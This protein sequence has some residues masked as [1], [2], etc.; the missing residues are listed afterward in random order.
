VRRFLITTAALLASLGTASAV[1]AEEVRVGA[2]S[3]PSVLAPGLPSPQHDALVVNVAR[4]AHLLFTVP[5]AG[6]PVLDATLRLHLPSPAPRTLEIRVAPATWTEESLTWRRAPRPGGVPVAT[7]PAGAQGD[8]AVD[9]G[10]VID[11]PGSYDVVVSTTG[12]R[13]A[14]IA[15]RESGRGAVLAL[16]RATEAQDAFARLAG[17]LGEA[18]SVDHDLR[19]TDGTRMDALGVVADPAGGYLGVAHTDDGGRFTTSLFASADLRRW[20]RVAGLQERSSQPALAALPGGG[21]LLAVEADE[22][23]PDGVRNGHLR[24]LRYPTTAALRSAAHDWRYDAPRTLSRMPDGFEGTPSLTVVAPDRVE[25]GFHHLTPDFVDRNGR[26]VLRG[27][28]GPAPTFTAA[29]ARDVDAPLLRLGV[30]GNIGDRDELSFGGARLLV[31][32]SQRVER[33]FGTWSVHV[34]DRAG[35]GAQRIAFRLPGGSR[36]VGNP[37]AT[38][39]PLP[40]G[41]PALVLTAFVFSEGAAPGEAGPMLAVLPLGGPRTSARSRPVGGTARSDRRAGVTGVRAR[42]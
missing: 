7:V 3:D 30:A 39:V 1:A 29:P 13:P 27:I 17:A 2:D 6:T 37:S 23:D 28:G 14:R 42:R 18:R 38:I 25:V 24:F 16:A 9:L 12:V 34:L 5:V 22:D 20:E 35:E 26:G 10:A 32:E 33:D 21:W 11:G 8:V 40:D 19:A 36:S 4:A 15:A 41:T 31:V